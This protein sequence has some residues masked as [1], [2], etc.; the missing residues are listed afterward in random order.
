[1]EGRR[2]GHS[3]YEECPEL[4]S[5][6][7]LSGNVGE[8]FL[9]QQFDGS[10]NS[11]QTES[12]DLTLSADTDV[13]ASEEEDEERTFSRG[14]SRSR[15][16]CGSEIIVTTC[17]SGEGSNASHSSSGSGSNSTTGG[18]SG[19]HSSSH[20]TGKSGPLPL[21]EVQVLKKV[22]KPLNEINTESLCYSKL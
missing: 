20:S 1:M 12:F 5:T 13:D 18:G 10:Q 11:A 3:F 9:T 6:P 17:D 21:H 22:R 19:S 15:S 16:L 14:R 8:Q 2:R 7:A 4:L